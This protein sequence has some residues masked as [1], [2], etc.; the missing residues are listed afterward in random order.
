MLPDVTELQPVVSKS[1]SSQ[2]EKCFADAGM[3]PLGESV[4]CKCICSEDR[5]CTFSLFPTFN[6]QLQKLLSRRVLH[7]HICSPHWCLALVFSF[8]LQG[9]VKISPGE[10][11]T[12]FGGD[13]AF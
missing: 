7:Y 11:G 10:E 13:L 4:P 6:K 5:L 3:F 2:R 1:L 12:M 8:N 9:T